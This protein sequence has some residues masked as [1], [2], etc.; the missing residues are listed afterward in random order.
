MS[1]RLKPNREAFEVVDGPDAGKRF[2]RGKTYDQV[3][4][5][6]KH[7]FE[8][9]PG[10]DTSA[11]L[12]KAMDPEKKPAPAKEKETDTAGA[13]PRPAF[14]SKKKEANKS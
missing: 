8:L 3:P 13:K 10:P 5:S 4:E 14:T 11:K 7:R 6:E 2:V 12:I 9:A 1:Y